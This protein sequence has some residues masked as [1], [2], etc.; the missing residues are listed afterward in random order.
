M[1][2]GKGRPPI[3]LPVDILKTNEKLQR[4]FAALSPALNSSTNT[5]LKEFENRYDTLFKPS[6]KQALD[7][8]LLVA[9]LQKAWR[10][11][12]PD[13]WLGLESNEMDVVDLIEQSGIPLVWAPRADTIEVILAADDPYA[14]LVSCDQPVLE[15]L[16]AVL[17]RASGADVAGHVE[18]CAFAEEALSAARD[19]HWSAAQALAASGL[20]HVIHEMLGFPLMGGLGAAFKKFN[21]SDVDEA[22]MTVLKQ[23]LLDVCS[24]RALTD[25][26]KTTTNGFNRHGTQHGDRKFF[27]AS[28]ALAGLLLLVGW[29]RE[30]TWVSETY[31]DQRAAAG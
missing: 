19:G 23:T 18:A 1:S 17:A 20:M 8:Y 25:I 10:H 15:D 24:A 21:A 22:T 13:N 14:A 9:D 2:A 16:D 7:S 3:Y 28:S 29:I 5:V 31:S 6:I 27:S 11:Y 12:I 26:A 4:T 30:F